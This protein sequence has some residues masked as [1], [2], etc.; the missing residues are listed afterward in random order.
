MIITIPQANGVKRSFGVY[1][2]E[3]CLRLTDLLPDGDDYSVLE[4][5]ASAP[6]GGI[7]RLHK[8]RSTGQ[9]ARK[10]A[11][12]VLGSL[13]DHL[14]ETGDH[15]QFPVAQQARLRIVAKTSQAVESIARRDTYQMVNLRKSKGRIFEMRFEYRRFGADHL[16]FLHLDRARYQRL[17]QYVEQGRAYDLH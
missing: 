10:I 13:F 15:F 14:I 1:N 16:R 12:D 4:L 17:C 8:V 7:C 5:K 6:T 9:L 3:H 2:D 11:L